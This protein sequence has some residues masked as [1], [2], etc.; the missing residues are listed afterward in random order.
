MSCYRDIKKATA[1]VIGVRL[2]RKA[3]TVKAH[4]A[5]RDL[6]VANPTSL[7]PATRGPARL[8]SLV[9]LQSRGGVWGQTTQRRGQPFPANGGAMKRGKYF[10]GEEAFRFIWEN[11]DRDGIWRGDAVSLGEEFDA[12]EDDAESVL[13][14]L[15]D[16]RLIERLCAGSF[17][18]SKRREE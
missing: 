14:E 3:S 17:Y 12:S 13:D 15:R 9:D 5:I 6:I 16:R 10:D 1:E 11:A 2:V 8:L 18:L 4:E 7:V